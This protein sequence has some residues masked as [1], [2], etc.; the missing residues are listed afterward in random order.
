[1][2]RQVHASGYLPAASMHFEV[3]VLSELVD[4]NEDAAMS[5]G[6]ARLGPAVTASLPYGGDARGKFADRSACSQY[7]ATIPSHPLH[8]CT[9]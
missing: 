5:C 8:P 6:R 1:M 9:R 4:I 2:G 3:R 7:R